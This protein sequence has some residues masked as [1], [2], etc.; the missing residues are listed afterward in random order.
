MKVNI[1]IELTDFRKKIF[2]IHSKLS[3]NE[4]I[5]IKT[6]DELIILNGLIY[7]SEHFNEY[8][9]NIKNFFKPL[10][11]KNLKEKLDITSNFEYLLSDA[12][13]IDKITENINFLNSFL[14]S[15]Y[16]GYSIRNLF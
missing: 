10:Y 2:D 6:E 14:T 9:D 13:H 4:D 5:N 3:N 7:I 16:Y 15:T 11:I 8:E 12:I 1:N